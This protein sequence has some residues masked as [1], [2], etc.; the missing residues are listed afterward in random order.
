M[1]FVQ[2]LAAQTQ[3]CTG[4]DLAAIAREAALAALTESLDATVVGHRH[5]AAAMQ[6]TL[7]RQSFRHCSHTFQHTARH[8]CHLLLPVPVAAQVVKPS[9]QPASQQQMYRKFSRS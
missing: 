7:W 6:D 5:F 9:V 4:A 2:G 3:G 1:L 8:T